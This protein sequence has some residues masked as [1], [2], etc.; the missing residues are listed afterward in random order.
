M[1]VGTIVIA[2]LVCIALAIAGY[3]VAMH[4]KGKIVISLP[5]TQ[6]APGDEI[7]GSFELTTK[8]AIESNK[9]LVILRAER[10]YERR[11]SDGDR[12]SQWR[13]IFRNEVQVDGPKTY[14]AGQT[15]SRE[16][17]IMVPT[18]AELTRSHSSGL[19]VSIGPVSFDTGRD[20]IRWSV[21][22]RLDCPGVDLSAK[23]TIY[24]RN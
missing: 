10:E 8:K 11:D 18:D 9:L 24:I 14:A 19:E 3:F 21:L 6:F 15:E 7:Q 16:F 17:S 23:Q 20:R 1:D 5:V 22:V 13:E 12:K 4:L 2:V